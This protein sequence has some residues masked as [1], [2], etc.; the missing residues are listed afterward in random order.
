M[1]LKINKKQWYDGVGTSF[2]ERSERVEGI[3]KELENHTEIA[4]GVLKMDGSFESN[5]YFYAIEELGTLLI[6]SNDI[7]SCRQLGSM[8]FYET[9]RDY[10]SR[11]KIGMN[12]YSTDFTSEA[13]DL[14][15]DVNESD[16]NPNYTMADL[17]EFDAMSVSNIKTLIKK[18][19]PMIGKI[20]I[21]TS[22]ELSEIHKKMIG[23][24]ASKCDETAQL[25]FDYLCK[26]MVESEIAEKIGMSQPAVNKRVGKICETLIG[27]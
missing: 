10:R 6:K 21:L 19:M 2:R 14:E 11:Y 22:N 12:S 1:T 27:Y 4:S 9:E 25:L 20:D 23:I 15:G 18:G 16:L 5:P 26:G 7:E 24:I 8:N 3:A 13:N 17:F